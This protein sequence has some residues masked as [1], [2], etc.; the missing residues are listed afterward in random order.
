M[1][2]NEIGK[3]VIELKTTEKGI[4]EMD[5]K[6]KSVIDEY[7]K[8]SM[9]QAMAQSIAQGIEIGKVQ[10]IEIGKV[11]GI[12][13][14][15]VQGI[16]LGEKKSSSEIALRMKEKGYSAEE[17]ASLVGPGYADVSRT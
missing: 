5:K 6:L 11:Q 10:G 14:G 13:I 2:Y 12:E 4:S 7:M 17:I 16:E 3:R 15:K 1:Y 8:D 9:D